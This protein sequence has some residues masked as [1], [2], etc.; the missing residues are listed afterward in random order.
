[1]SSPGLMSRPNNWIT[2]KDQIPS[3]SIAVPVQSDKITANDS[4]FSPAQCFH[5]S[6]GQKEVIRH[7]PSALPLG[8]Y[9]VLTRQRLMRPYKITIN[10]IISSPGI[11]IIIIP[12]LDNSM[13]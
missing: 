2:V 4:M 11:V 9:R 7:K 3:P 12:G 1:M 13:F 5:R 6:S 8:C 10:D